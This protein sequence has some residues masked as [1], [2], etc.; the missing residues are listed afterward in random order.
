MPLPPKRSKA[1]GRCY[2][3]FSEATLRFTT[4]RTIARLEALV[5]L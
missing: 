1:R 3:Y 4:L 5:L 2:A